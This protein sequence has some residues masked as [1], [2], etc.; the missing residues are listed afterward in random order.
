MSVD[1]VKFQHVIENQLPQYVVDEFPLLPEFLKQYY[2]SQ[3]FQSG[4]SDLIQNIDKYVKMDEI[5]N[6]SNSTVLF[7]DISSYDTSIKTSLNG[8]FTEG[9][10]NTHGL[11]KIDNEIIFY[12]SKTD[13]SFEGCS[14]GF[15]GVSSYISKEDP[16][17]L[18]FSN[19]EID[20]H[21]SG[22]IIYNLNVVFLQEFFKKIKKQIAPGF[23]DRS[24]FSEVDKKNLIFG[25]KSFYES[26]G[27][28]KSFEILFKSLYGDDVKIIHP[29]TLLFRPSDSDYRVSYDFVVESFGLDLLNYKNRTLFQTNSNAKGVVSKVEKINYDGGNFYQIGL[30]VGYN[31]DI[32]TKGSIYGEFNVN[33]KT[34]LLNYANIGDTILDVDSTL[35]FPNSGNLEVYDISGNVLS[36]KYNGKSINQFYNV[37]G[38][39]S[40]IDA[41][42]DIRNDDYVY[43][44]ING[45]KSFKGR[46]TSTLKEFK[47]SGKINNFR[48]GESINIQTFGIDGKDIRNRNWISNVKSNMEVVSITTIDDVEG[49][50]EIE[51]HDN[52]YYKLGFLL[53]I[54]NDDSDYFYGEIRN[55]ISSN[56]FVI[57]TLKIDDNSNL[58]IKGSNFT[59]ENQLLKG[60][61]L[62]FP[63]INQYH[64]NVQNTY[65]KFDG[66]TIV[67][68][69]SIPNYFNLQTSPQSRSLS[70]SGSANGDLIKLTDNIDHDFYTGDA[71]FYQSGFTTTAEYDNDGNE[72]IV[73]TF[74]KFDNL[75]ELVY[76]VYRIDKEYIKLAKSKSDLYSKRFISPTGTVSDN[77][78]IYYNFYNKSLSPQGIVREILKPVNKS[79]NFV[80]EPGYTGILNNGVE[81]L[82]YKSSDKI[83]YGEIKSIEVG[84]GGDNYDV[85]NPPKL[86]IIDE[87][88]ASVD[89]PQY[90][91]VGATGTISVT[92]TL[93]DI[94]IED[95][96]FGY[97]EPPTVSIIGGNGKKA[98]AETEIVFV[99]H[100]VT[101]DAGTSLD[102][103]GLLTHGGISPANETIG[104]ST[105]HRFYSGE[106]IICNTNNNQ[107][108]LSRRTRPRG[109]GWDPYIS[110][111]DVYINNGEQ[112]YAHVVDDKTITL[113]TDYDASLSGISTVL[114]R[115]LGEGIQEF[116]AEKKKGVVSSLKIIDS[117]ENYAYKERTI[118]SSGIHTG[119]NQFTIKNHRYESK[120]I[121][122]YT[123]GSVSIDGIS[124]T[125][126]YYVIKI[127]NDNFKLSLVGSG[128]TSK[129]YYYNNDIFVDIKSKG[130][131]SFNYEPI[132]VTVS[133]VIDVPQSVSQDFSCKVQ[134]IIR[135]SIDSINLSNNGVG[136][137]SSDVFNFNRKPLI[138]IQ[139]GSNALLKAI[140]SNGKIVDVVVVDGGKNYFSKPDISII[141]PK[142]K[143]CRLVP[144]IENGVIKSINV[145][146]NGV[147]Y[148]K[149]KVELHVIPAGSNAIIEPILQQWNVNLVERFISNIG[150]DDGF[151]SNNIANNSL[152][153]SHIYAPR[154]LR[155]T[156]NSLS[157]DGNLLY[158]TFDLLKEK[159]IEIDN[160]NH[161]SIIGWAYDGNPIYGP[162]GYSNGV[163]GSI[164]Q[165]ES[166]YQIIED[167][168]I[169]NR[170]PGSIYPAGF[171]IEDYIYA[172]NGDL[173]QNNGRYCNTPDYP[174]GVYAYFAT[175]NSTIDSYG[176]FLNY[177][178][179]KFPYLIGNSFKSE[180]NLFNFKTISNQSEYNIESKSWFRNTRDY[181]FKKSKSGYEYVFDSNKIFPQE[182]D[183][184][185]S[186]SGL[187]DFVK[188][189]SG[190]DDYQVGN[191]LTF[192]NTDT[193][194][195]NVSAKVSMIGGEEINNISIAS[196]F[197]DNVEFSSS[198]NRN[199]FIGFTTVPHK[200]NNNDILSISGF[201]T[202]VGK[203]NGIYNVGIS[204]NVL[205]LISP[206]N[207]ASSTG[208]VTYFSV[209]GNL[210][211]SSIRPNDILGIGTE[212]VKVLNIEP[213]SKRIRVLRNQD[214]TIG[215]SHTAMTVI[216]SDT[217][218]IKFTSNNIDKFNTCK[219]NTELY[220]NPLESVGLG[221][222]VATGTGTT[223]TF[224][225]PGSGTTQ[226][227]V[228]PRSIYY[229]N[230]G[231]KLNDKVKYKVNGGSSIVIRRNADGGNENLTSYGDNLYV[232]PLTKDTIG[233]STNKVGMGTTGQYVGIT[234]TNGL[235]YF[236][237]AGSGFYHSFKTDFDDVI[238]GSVEHIDTT[239]QTKTP[240]N[241]L[242][243]DLVNISVNPTGI[244]TV[245][246]KYDDYNSRIIFD[247]LTFA[248]GDVNIINNTI[249][250]NNHKFKKGDK[251][252][253][254]STSTPVGGLVN[255][256]I[257]YV[258]P[259]N[260]DKIQLVEEKFNLGLNNDNIVNFT[261]AAAGIISKINP[262]IEVE[263]NITLK[264]DLS[265]QSLSFISGE[266]TYPAFDMNLYSDQEFVNEYINS[267]NKLGGFVNDVQKSGIVGTAGANLTIS[268]NDTIPKILWYKFDKINL[269][270]IT[271]IKN[272]LKIDLDVNN[273]NQISIV[274]NK[275]NSFHKVSLS[276]IGS[277]EFKIN[278][279]KKP[280][281]SF[282]D[283]N[284][285]KLSYDT[286]SNQALGPIKLVKITNSG[287]GYKSLPS[288]VSVSSTT[289]NG[290]LLKC[291]SNDIG[292]VLS[293][294]FKSDRIGFD[295]PTDNTMRI[296]SNLPEIVEI[297]TL[298]SFEYIGISSNGINYLTT[299]DLVVV[300]GYTNTI[301]KDIDLKF[302]LGDNEVQILSNTTSLHDSS[303]KIVPVNNSNGVGIHSIGWNN[304]NKQT[305]VYFYKFTSE[306][307]CPFNVGDEVFIEGVSVGVGSTGI[308]Y[309]SS[310]YNYAY[311]KVLS[312]DLN[313]GG[314]N[315]SIVLDY[316]KNISKT[317][318]PGSYDSRR[319]YGKAIPVS[320]FP[321]FKSVM[322]KNNFLDGE[323][324]L[325]GFEIGTL[326][327]WDRTFGYA[328]ISTPTEFKKGDYLEGLT[329]GTKGIIGNKINYDSEIITGAGVTI[330]NGWE[331]NTGFLNEPSQKL[332]NNEYYQNFSYSIS[333]KIP[334]TEWEDIV[335]STTHTVGFDKYSDLQV[336]S[337]NADIG[338]EPYDSE[339]SL[340]IEIVSE[341]SVHSYY[342]FD[343]VSERAFGVEDYNLSK[344]VYFQN[345]ILTDHYLSIG[346]RV[347]SID[348]ISDKF[349]SNKRIDNYVDLGSFNTS[350]IYNKIFTLIK[351]TTY[352]NRQ[353]SVLS[354]IQNSEKAWYNEYAKVVHGLDIGNYDF[355]NKKGLWSLR[356]YPTSY[357]FNNYIFS[358]ASI[359]IYDS[360]DSGISTDRVSIGSSDLHLLQGK[361]ANVSIGTTTNLISIASSEFR[362]AK[363][364][365]Y[366]E[367]NQ[368]NYYSNELNMIHDGTNVYFV[369]YGNLETNN[370]DEFGGADVGVGTYN[371]YI[372]SG[373]LKLDFI[374]NSNV[375]VALTANYSMILTHAT[376][377]GYGSTTLA[378]SS[379]YISHRIGTNYVGIGSTTSPIANEIFRYNNL[380]EDVSG[381]YFLINIS[382]TTNNKHEFA[383]LVVCNTQD[384]DFFTEYG[385]VYTDQNLSTGIG[386]FGIKFES[387]STKLTYTPEA[388]INVEV[389]IFSKEL[390]FR[391]EYTSS[392]DTELRTN[393]LEISSVYGRYGGILLETQ[394]E[395]D[396]K[397]NGD[398]I[399][400]RDF[401]G[402][403]SNIVDINRNMI[404]TQ[405]HFFVTGEQVTYEQTGSRGEESNFY[406]VGIAA[407]NVPGI[408]VTDKL[409]R[410]NLY[411]VKVGDLG[412]RFALS[413]AD[414]LNEPLPKVLTFSNVGIGTIHT[415]KGLHQN[416]KCLMALDNMIQSPIAKTTVSTKLLETINEQTDIRVSGISSIFSRDIIRIDDEIMEVIAPY[417]DGSNFYLRVVRGQLAT[418]LSTHAN[419][420]T[421][422][423]LTGN[424]NIKDN[425]I[426][427]IES[428]KGLVPLSTDRY[429]PNE[430]DWTGITTFS[431]FQ[432]RVFTR[433]TSAGLTTH[434]YSENVIFDDISDE[435]TGIRSEFTLKSSG[436]AVTA[437]SGNNAVILINDVMQQP[438]G[439]VI[440]A[441]E[442]PNYDFVSSTGV[443]TVRFQGNPYTFTRD[444]NAGTLP[445]GGIIVEVGS[446][447]GFAY[448]PLV[449]AGGT[450]V[451][452]GLGTISSISIGNSGSGYRSGIQTF[453]NVGVQTF[454]DGIPNIEFIGNASISGGHI[455]SVAITNPGSGYTI[456]N[457]PSVVFDSPLPYSNIPLIYSSDS[458][459]GQ[460]TGGFIDVVVGNGSS[461]IDFTLKQ[462]GSGYGNREI[463]TV[464]IGGT[465]GIPTNT[466][467]TY[468]EFQLTV[469]R[470][471]KDEFNG[472]FFGQF[473]VFDS[474]EKYFDGNTR[475]YGLKVGGESVAIVSQK[476]S[477]I[478]ITDTIL[479]FVNNILQSPGISYNLFSGSSITF[480]EAPKEGDTCNILFYKGTKGID[481]IF[482]DILTTVQKGDSIKIVNN[483]LLGQGFGLQQEERV[484][485]GIATVDNISTNPYR[486]PGVSTDFSLN[487]PVNWYRQTSDRIVDGVKIA[488]DRQHYEPNIYPNSPIISNVGI[489][490]DVIYVANIRPLFR[491]S[492]ESISETYRNKIL[493]VSQDEI[494]D[495]SATSTVNSSGNVSSIS[496]TESGKGYKRIPTVGISAPTS[497]TKATA[498]AIMSVKN[499]IERI[500]ITNSGSGYDQNNPPSIFI[501]SPS[502]DY[503]SLDVK[504]NGYSGDY[505]SIVGLG[506]TT[507]GSKSQ[508]IF[509]FFIP[510]DSYLREDNNYYKLNP[511]VLS[512]ISTGDYFTVFDSYSNHAGGLGL[513]SKDKNDNERIGIGSFMNNVYQADS[514]ETVSINVTGVGV[515]NV[516]RV[517]TNIVGPSSTSSAQLDNSVGSASTVR[518]DTTSLKFDSVVFSSFS[519]LGIGSSRYFGSYSWGKIIIDKRPNPKNY[520]AYTM[521]GYSGI[522]TSSYVRRTNQLRYNYV[523]YETLYEGL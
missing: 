488:K 454:S 258:I 214:N 194:G 252:I 18:E 361:T 349:D 239:I 456:S 242:S 346:N 191:P 233:L 348:N 468:D 396:L 425:T 521:N 510:L 264:F 150:S 199:T 300:D 401:D 405:N 296:V 244:T 142:G 29:K 517:F 304:T 481:V 28:D 160:K 192:D 388:N 494:I 367:D 180:P 57:K 462:G 351:D 390:Y 100:I 428:P 54:T 394:T 293:T 126:K 362:S 251:I 451:V 74:S 26:K 324:V 475:V 204:S 134:P 182:L 122:Q 479:V 312:R 267:G 297:D 501:E 446:N 227:F 219:V 140:V 184:S 133:G 66:D 364:D 243:G 40:S 439:D 466:T 62:D 465:V 198:S 432:G 197:F 190:G 480:T 305:T 102:G 355:I 459:V 21:K 317:D 228:Y 225:N 330:I 215:S 478:N 430:I 16:E 241:L 338:V 385:T 185:S 523:D 291:F 435:F 229:P 486:S 503:E 490:T 515:T 209:S 226:A 416:T 342:D 221:T 420:T 341:S 161:S 254:T 203:L 33:P 156:T 73:K 240:H 77:K 202:N 131:G 39:I 43:V 256:K 391:N 461:I 332:P 299:P 51:T 187:I 519:H 112:F 339:S 72:Y 82:N 111:K 24:L 315:A 504:E 509:D 378:T 127:D 402:S 80:T 340:D 371:A 413:A 321:V 421:V 104:F 335:S 491:M 470:A 23:D 436:I 270:L 60:N 395:F 114:I 89:P 273:Y 381:G 329:S 210:T 418:K 162:Y 507:V 168:N 437:A 310:S 115:S 274:N 174:N 295:Y 477:K 237:S 287:I 177:K 105:Y 20:T 375:G 178:K 441:L 453:V 449:S 458:V 236:T 193:S 124:S 487:R 22:A 170:P 506:T 484:V 294:R 136:Y 370:L 149:D 98:I 398:Y 88:D 158:N 516:R 12:E 493:I 445:R 406:N 282:Y 314:L 86:H 290:A 117:G 165:M 155:E 246:V 30:D 268:I 450:A 311:F 292:D 166:S 286:N 424:Y 426:S 118:V 372:D 181:Q 93:Q 175:F 27:T 144:I 447:Q 19:S 407:T 269:N 334:Y 211:P 322:K 280:N 392:N 272:D 352:T 376:S 319:S 169:D 125:E 365:I 58:S 205:V 3:E 423:K 399:F 68:S 452:S 400:S 415:I 276:G 56:K 412:I 42:T 255:E 440:N 139:N 343:Y 393:N 508:L 357:N 473:E 167:I 379:N 232:A 522:D 137:G 6:L 7:S 259:F 70:F 145:Q 347:V 67:A 48:Y 195:K 63:S 231:L 84:S 71:I 176:T 455:V 81:I 101:F 135:G 386:T 448:Q 15:V 97:I 46:I 438:D 313:I 64:A 2:I 159:G 373:N 78:F 34:K 110:P 389:R 260:K 132:V 119:F 476:G 327:R 47:S 387:A 410:Q 172:L 496:V 368:R 10:P 99:D 328:K 213:E 354:Y 463:L 431:T 38:V 49:I 183:I 434:T 320:H 499:T 514:V 248:S 278:I 403:D 83:F 284:N 90:L 377:T 460:G 52:H 206:I 154:I 157:G 350:R 13:N 302:E 247:P 318:Y 457:P 345:R 59:I 108:I 433:T 443:S 152:Q 94:R 147:G 249:T 511:I 307:E 502:F 238:V 309:N 146:N 257:Y 148:D 518:F 366:F 253:H 207:L 469:N 91:G 283:E 218:K 444:S 419:D 308:G 374:P 497:G 50:Y 250:F 130:T 316:S 414:A 245:V 153:Y 495:A 128:L 171:F 298:S 427:F 123:A 8:N 363:L 492:A 222:I 474:P 116:K 429:G 11:I 9:F 382:D 333:S 76:Y 482:R 409:P 200:Y 87:L 113:H 326:E 14:R 55:T 196:S 281:L 359:G 262:L 279:D 485:V 467:Q 520:N 120:D 336:V 230:H 4:P 483:Q 179:P 96:G 85:L 212:R 397:N 61:S 189:L 36:L 325:S 216:Y 422:E 513:V 301:V 489:D 383:E 323:K 223:I 353:V 498:I 464:A 275:L 288:V 500:D 31:R 331:K 53:K 138:T 360:V 234:T 173:D 103:G 45:V 472:W 417:Q 65:S 442:N 411:V 289:G 384:D 220:F 505:G 404:V 25:L 208:I 107:A 471:N 369:E 121:V 235:L 75:E 306:D 95:G 217:N 37:T 344:E 271:S 263:K 109:G 277:T 32:D 35:G 201:T 380:V 92:G 358:S 261:S 224:S 17:K 285:S 186:S 164:K 265:D 69:N 41:K 106:K 408:G 356:F 163:S 44:I 5:F 151:I 512:G 337:Y 303:P 266:D 1:R 79:G 141:D 143:Y 188:I 129:D